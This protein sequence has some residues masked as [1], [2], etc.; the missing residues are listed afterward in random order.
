MSELH[1]VTKAFV[2][3][4][5]AECSRLE[6][7]I[8]AREGSAPG[9]EELPAKK[10]SAPPA[11]VKERATKPPQ[12]GK[13]KGPR[14][15]TAPASDDAPVARKGHVP[16]VGVQQAFCADDRERVAK[17]AALKAA[18]YRR[19]GPTERLTAGLFDVRPS[20]DGDGSSTVLWR[21][22]EAPE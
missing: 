8:A 7:I 6:T 18:G 4:L 3:L 10:A 22:I 1:A 11:A 16:R 17:V 20:G 9:A 12:K 14:K 15:L 19:C 2:R 13:H 5:R 21:E